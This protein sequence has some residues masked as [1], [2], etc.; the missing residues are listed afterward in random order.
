MLK[1]QLRDIRKY[2]DGLYSPSYL[3]GLWQIIQVL[4]SGEC[5]KQVIKQ[6]NRYLAIL[7]HKPCVETRGRTCEIFSSVLEACIETKQK[8]EVER[9]CSRVA[10]YIRTNIYIYREYILFFQCINSCLNL[11]CLRAGRVV[12]LKFLSV[13]VKCDLLECHVNSMMNLGYLL[14][15]L[16]ASQQNIIN[17]FLDKI[18]SLYQEQ[19]YTN[20]G[21]YKYLQHIISYNKQY[22][23]SDKGRYSERKKEYY[24]AIYIHFGQQFLKN[25]KSEWG[26]YV[27]DEKK[28]ELIPWKHPFHH[29]FANMKNDKMMK[30][31]YISKGQVHMHLLHTAQTQNLF[32]NIFPGESI[33]FTSAL[34]YHLRNLFL[35]S[36]LHLNE[37]C[38]K[39]IPSF[40][41]FATDLF[42]LTFVQVS[43]IGLDIGKSIQKVQHL[44]EKRKR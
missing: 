14:L 40:L 29:L 19:K 34:K 18:N 21:H 36:K 22:S 26:E 12:I 27:W 30:I 38:L 37:T 15:L 10:Q 25:R 20:C 6:G 39:M 23:T 24:D 33:G 1:K 28:A 41:S 43:E 13:N 31:Q 9:I 16:S 44:E 2:A 3:D 32:Y 8:E 5:W 42:Q 4:T 35:V 7:R 11:H 17:S